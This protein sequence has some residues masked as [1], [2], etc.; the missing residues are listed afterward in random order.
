[1]VQTFLFLFFIKEKRTDTDEIPPIDYNRNVIIHK[2]FIL[3]YS[4]PIDCVWHT[5]LLSILEAI[6]IRGKLL[7]WFQKLSFMSHAGYRN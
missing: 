5:G 7:H 2:R 6:G 1:M 4:N 3:T